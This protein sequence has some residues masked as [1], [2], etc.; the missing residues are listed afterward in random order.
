MHPAIKEGEIITVVPIS[1]FDIKRGDILLYIVG[2]K[3]IAHRV[4][5]IKREKTDST[6]RSS[7][8]LSTRPTT[9]ST[10]NSSTYSS[11]Q[12]LTHSN[13]LNP[14]LIFI[15]QGDASAICDEPV[16]AQQVLGKV[17]SV[18]RGSRSI[19]LYS[20]RARMLRTAHVWASRLKRRIIRIF[21]WVRGLKLFLRPER[22]DGVRIVKSKDL[23]L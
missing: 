13:A 7:A 22:E 4:V 2:K 23:T 14:Q 11:T 10:A 18:E 1:S 5:S 3:V 21:P 17:V 8:N 15:L 20:R 6:S 19:D 9:H 16:E 12:A